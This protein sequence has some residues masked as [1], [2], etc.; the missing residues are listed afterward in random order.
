MIA[1]ASS[2][3]V[4]K[5]TGAPSIRLLIAFVIAK[6]LFVTSVL[7]AEDSSESL[8]IPAGISESGIFPVPSRDA[9]PSI[10]PTSERGTY[11]FAAVLPNDATAVSV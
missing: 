9:T 8:V 5:A 2:L 11:V 6:F 7:I 3:S 4:S 1:A 10:F